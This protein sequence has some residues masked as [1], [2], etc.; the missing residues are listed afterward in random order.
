MS[1]LST[2]R[3][4]RDSAEHLNQEQGSVV[5]GD[6][7]DTQTAGRP[8]VWCYRYISRG[9]TEGV[10]YVSVTTFYITVTDVS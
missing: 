8:S 1:R 7:Q 2:H 10:T 4:L 5:I 3:S 9:V 6:E